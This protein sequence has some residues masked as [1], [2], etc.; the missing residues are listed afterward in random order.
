MP[1]PIIKTV[2]RGE[3]GINDTGLPF[4]TRDGS[5]SFGTARA[6]KIYAESPNISSEIPEDP[7][8]F[9]VHITIKN[10]IVANPHDPFVDLV[11]LRPHIGDERTLEMARDLHAHLENTD[12]F[13]TLLE[14]HQCGDLD[15][16]VEKQGIDILDEIYIDA[17]PIFDSEK[18]VGWFKEA[19][20]D[21]AMHKGAGE[22]MDEQEYKIF[23]QDQAKILEVIP[24][25]PKKSVKASEPA[26]G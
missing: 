7:R 9:K 26:M 22:T 21:G 4:H 5:I 25:G 6:A 16:L 23:S 13:L 15:E 2:Y 18:Y 1:D 14:E 17:Y 3:H 12:N 10:P 20:F 11:E 24:V 19:G 8:V